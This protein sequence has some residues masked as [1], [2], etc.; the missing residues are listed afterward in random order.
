MI[1][2]WMFFINLN[3]SRT[4]YTYIFS[5]VQTITRL[6][7]TLNMNTLII[8]FCLWFS[9]GV[10]ALHD[11]NLDDRSY[12]EPP[13]CKDPIAYSFCLPDCLEGGTIIDDC[14]ATCGKFNYG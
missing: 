1:E 5:T 9:F 8:L 7:I 14:F 12:L 10:N 11:N 6:Q 13:N 2:T 3:V 4:T